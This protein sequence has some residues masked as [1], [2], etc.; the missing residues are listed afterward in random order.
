MFAPPLPAAKLH[1]VRE[2]LPQNIPNV[3]QYMQNTHRPSVVQNIR[4][5]DSIQEIN[6]ELLQIISNGIN[7]I[8]MRLKNR[9]GSDFAESNQNALEITNMLNSLEMQIRQDI[10]SNIGDRNVET[11]NIERDIVTNIYRETPHS[12]KNYT[13]AIKHGSV[14]FNTLDD[15]N[16]QNNPNTIFNDANIQ[17]QITNSNRNNGTD[18]DIN[19]DQLMSRLLN[20][21]NLEF[22]Y[23]KKHDELMKVFAFTMNLFTKYKYAIKIILFLLKNLVNKDPQDGTPQPQPQPP[24]QSGTIKLPVR[25]IT[26]IKKLVEDQET[27]QGVIDKMDAAIIKTDIPLPAGLNLDQTIN[28]ARPKL[29]KATSP[30]GGIPQPVVEATLNA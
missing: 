15:Q 3:M 20:C 17:T 29:A 21:Q 9:L 4:N 10:E 16:D 1:S 2:I 5:S 30:I 22:L 14:N 8:V 12:R 27:I 24:P 19:S 6:N 25:I 28:D 26:N 11:Q 18:V 13:D 7:G 23:L